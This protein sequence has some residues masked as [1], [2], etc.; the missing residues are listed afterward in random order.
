ML[1]L[2]K[3]DTQ[4]GYKVEWNCTIT[5]D[6]TILVELDPSN[7]G[8]YWEWVREL[9]PDSLEVDVLKAIEEAKEIL[10][11]RYRLFLKNQKFKKIVQNQSVVEYIQ[12]D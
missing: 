7:G 9:T 1:R 3:R 11:G 4:V 5:K 2:L 6:S 10:R 8:K 12:E